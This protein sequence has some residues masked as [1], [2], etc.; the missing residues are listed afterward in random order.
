MDARRH[1]QD[2]MLHRPTR[3]G[4]L[5]RRLHIRLRGVHIFVSVLSDIRPR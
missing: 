4:A 5:A 1:V 3:V 2:F